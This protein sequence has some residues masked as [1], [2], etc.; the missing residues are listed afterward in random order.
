V[1]WLIASDDAPK[2][3]PVGTAFTSSDIDYTLSIEAGGLQPFTQY[4]YQFSVCNSNNVSPMGRTKTALNA[5]GDVTPVSVAI[6]SCSKYASDFPSLTKS[7]TVNS[8]PFD[9]FN[10]YSNSVQKDSIGYATHLGDYIYEYANSKHLVPLA[11]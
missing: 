10:A 3:G 5:D 8:F 2:S 9:F 6:Y 11:F 4:Y 1:S 7:L